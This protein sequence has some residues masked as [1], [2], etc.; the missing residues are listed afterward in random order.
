MHMSKKWESRAWSRRMYTATPRFLE[1]SCRS[2]K[3]SMSE[4]TSI[5]TAITYENEAGREV[6]N[7]KHHPHTHSLLQQCGPPLTISSFPPQRHPGTR[8]SHILG[9]PSQ[10]TLSNAP[11]LPSPHWQT[12]HLSSVPSLNP[13]FQDQFGLASCLGS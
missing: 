11:S 10:L 9:W 12:S 3:M 13:T 8:I 5:T 4:K 1:I 2:L 7:S 6:R